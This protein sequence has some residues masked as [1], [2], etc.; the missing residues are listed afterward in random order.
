MSQTAL[1]EVR[2][3]ALMPRTSAYDIR[4]TTLQGLGVTRS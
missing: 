1:S 3:E 2:V 4:D